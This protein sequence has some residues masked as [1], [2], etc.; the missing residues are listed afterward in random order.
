MTS[1]ALACVCF[2]FTTS[3]SACVAPQSATNA[4]VV[5]RPATDMRDLIARFEADRGAVQRLWRV[6]GS[7]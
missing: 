2:A 6:E 1:P 4:A 5:A 3:L 7:W